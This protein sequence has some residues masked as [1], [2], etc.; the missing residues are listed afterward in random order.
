MIGSDQKRREIMQPMTKV[1]APCIPADYMRRSTLTKRFQKAIQQ[2]IILVI[3]PAGYGKTTFLCDSLS[4]INHPI[5][6]LSLD[7][8]DDHVFGFWNSLIMAVR[9]IEP[10]FGEEAL[11]SLQDSKIDMEITLTALINEMI[12]IVPDLYIVLD[13]Y[14]V[15]E[16]QAIHESLSFLMRYLPPQA[17]LILS[18][19]NYP[20]LSLDRLRGQG[21]VAEI[22]TIDLRFTLEE[23]T[24]LLNHL[25]EVP[26]TESTIR[27]LYSQT[28]GWITGLR[29]IVIAML[30]NADVNVLLTSMG[31]SPKGI[32]G[33]L[34]SELLD[35]QEEA[36]RQFLLET[37]VFDRF[38]ARMCDSIFKR[39]DSREMINLVTA[40]NLFLQPI[41]SDGEWFRYHALFRSA[42]YEKMSAGQKDNLTH[43][44][45]RASLWYEQEGRLEDA[46]EHALEADEYERTLSLLDKIVII[47][48]GQDH[49]DRFWD[50]LERLPEN[51]LSNSLWANIGCAV[52]CE[53]TRSN[54]QEKQYRQAAF[55]ISDTR[56]IAAYQDSPHY[57]SL[58]GTL[59]VL[60]ILEAYHLGNIPQAIQY[61]E[62]GLAAIPENE[63][64][65]R[66]GILCMMGF[67]HWM[68]G[69][70]M[71]AYRCCEEAASLGETAKWQYSVCLNL[72]A[73][74]HIRFAR[75]HLSSAAETCHQIF[76]KG[77]QEGKEISS[78]C[79]AHLLLARIL[80]QRNLLAEAEEQIHQAVSLSE[81]G[82]EPMLW[83]N[84]QMALA[85]IRISCG[86]TK[87]AMEI[88]SRAKITFDGTYPDNSLA[89]MLMARLYLMI[90]ESSI[91]TD[92]LGHLFYT[93]NQNLTEKSHVAEIL[94]HDV[95]G[96]DVRNVWS[97]TP[98]LIYVRVRLAQ[99]DT[100][101]LSELLEIVHRDAE[102]KGWKNLLIETIILEALVHDTAGDSRTALKVLTEALMLTEQ[103]DYLR[104][105]VDE[106]YPMHA[107]LQHA[108]RKGIHPDYVA[109]LLALFNEPGEKIAVSATSDR[110][111]DRHDDAGLLTKREKEIL[112][113]ICRG[114]TNQEIAKKLFL[115]LSTVK[116]HIQTIYE[117][118]DANNRTQAV[119]RAQDRGLFNPKETADSDQ[120]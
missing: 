63:I 61:A 95:Y 116:N 78:A 120:R 81:K 29:M 4:Q 70:L 30:G 51:L 11:S 49:Y 114:A 45:L 25:M 21:H 102:T 69:E 85:R 55:S 90:G 9:K 46:L 23:T 40:R 76:S 58:L 83:L 39:N 59:S 41:D 75:F 53:M 108:R 82:Q 2:K 71:K 79:Y 99:K 87:A 62:E 8:R 37:S 96:N 5:A 73:V 89:D 113:L 10:S 100:E 43:L 13:D 88:A 18:S 50:W 117:K 38:S 91:A 84:C 14:H 68:N 47:I 77:L 80:Y 64:R 86:E 3:A 60:K 67:S 111:S 97:E 104:I 66:C 20:P 101:G 94:Q 12:A 6:W 65:G 115:S 24:E 16:S 42:L 56:G 15:I 44:H 105:F 35:Q 26:L 32:M 1:I 54:E 36:V 52:S 109:K 34:T 98:L 72:S 22:G 107:L 17:H 28:E 7:K 31:K 74:A 57:S 93:Q 48:M 118:L 112:E 103:E 19:R 33:Y 92:Y 119:I 27:H 106:G 110:T